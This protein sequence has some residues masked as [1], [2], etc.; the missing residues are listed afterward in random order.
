[1]NVIHCLQRCDSQDIKKIGVELSNLLQAR[2]DADYK[3]DKRI[4]LTKSQDIYNDANDL[5]LNFD[6]KIAI[7][8]NKQKFSQSS[9]QQARYAG[10]LT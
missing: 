4:T 5:L 6:S 3:M 9:I 7:S 2:T 8:N 1:M 10:I